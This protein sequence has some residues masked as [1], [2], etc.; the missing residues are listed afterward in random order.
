MRDFARS[1]PDRVR[2]CVHSRSQ[3]L[4]FTAL[5]IVL[6]AAPIQAQVAVPFSQNGLSLNSLSS[7]VTYTIALS[8]LPER[9]ELTAMVVPDAAHWDMSLQVEISGCTL[10]NPFGSCPSTRLSTQPTGSASVRYEPWRCVVGTTYPAYV[11]H[12]CNVKVRALDFGSA[13][14]PAQFD[15]SLRSTTVVPTSTIS[16]SITTN[17]VQTV[18]IAPSKDT[19]IYQL[20]PNSGNGLG[21]SFW[22]TGTTGKQLRSLL[23]FDVASAVPD[24]ATV[25]AARLEL[26][27]LS[28]S[29]TALLVLYAVPRDFSV[30]WVEGFD[31]AIGDEATPSG[32]TFGAATWSHRNWNPLSPQ[33]PWSSSG[34]DTQLPALLTSLVRP[35]GLVVATSPALV[36]HVALLASTSAFHDGLLLLADTG[37]V[38][39]AS[40]ENATIAQRPRLIVDYV[41]PPAPIESNLPTSTSTFVNEGQ[42]FRWIYDLD[43]D[44]VLMTPILGRCEVMETFGYILPYSYQ[45]QGSPTFTGVDCCA[46]QIDSQTGISG[47]GQA[48]FF[49][50]VDG[51]NPANQPLDVDQDGIKDLCDNCPNV[52]NGPLLGSC[53]TGSQIGN[54]C[55]SNQECDGGLCSFAQ[56]D[57]DLDGE[58]NAC[59]PEPSFVPGLVAGWVG[60]FALARR[61]T[62]VMRRT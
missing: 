55:H 25:L 6:G 36:D 58:G 53:I 3:A 27:A 20:N 30:S 33:G 5:S 1:G 60:L 7:E 59:V 28:V 10:V 45:F 9:P 46:W 43:R 13:G 14:A 62:T 54:L 49:I 40:D 61:R 37:S 12:T 21:E 4:L 34:G 44:N 31:D 15:L 35:T 50:N 22:A 26:N 51:G 57:Q 38:R 56:D 16:S 42:D 52:P 18:A 23:D 29:G 41:M 32:Q 47:S 48:L 39:F 11:G 19:T 2:H 8:S 24:G 17:P